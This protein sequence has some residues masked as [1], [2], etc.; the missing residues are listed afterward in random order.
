MFR[1]ACRLGCEGIVSKQ[2]ASPYRSGRA[3]TRIKVKNPGRGCPIGPR[4]H[5]DEARRI[6]AKYRRSAWANDAAQS[7]IG[8]ADDQNSD[9]G[10]WALRN[11]VKLGRIGS[12]ESVSRTAPRAPAVCISRPVPRV[13]ACV[14]R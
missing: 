13:S 12:F 1:H 10:V 6:A 4:A 8:Q 5:H 9:V 7:P 11:H 3:R 14:R 2:R